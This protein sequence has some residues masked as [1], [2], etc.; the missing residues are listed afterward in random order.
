MHMY[1]HILVIGEGMGH[2]PDIALGHH[3]LSGQFLDF[4][5]ITP[6]H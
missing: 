3:E 5:K 4:S 6:G 1:K 2:M